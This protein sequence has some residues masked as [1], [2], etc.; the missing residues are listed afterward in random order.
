M[1]NFAVCSSSL[2][3]FFCVVLACGVMW[4]VMETRMLGNSE[5]FFRL[6]QH[7]FVSF[8]NCLRSIGISLQFVNHSRCEMYCVWR[9]AG[10][11]LTA[12]P[13]QAF[14]KLFYLF[15]KVILVDLE[16]SNL[17]WFIL[18]SYKDRNLTLVFQWHQR[19]D[20]FSMGF[21]RSLSRYPTH[22]GVLKTCLFCLKV[23]F[24]D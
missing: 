8:F 7:F 16:I 19:W 5:V 14:W 6:D 17:C 1:N 9:N 22:P 21:Y 13:T 18:S 12:P 20:L 23:I 15:W 10:R 4:L 2:L 11:R 24:V 3:T